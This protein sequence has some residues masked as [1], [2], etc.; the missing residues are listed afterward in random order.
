[1]YHNTCEEVSNST[2]LT[3]TSSAKSSSNDVSRNGGGGGQ[4]KVPI[5]SLYNH[6]VRSHRNL[7]NLAKVPDNFSLHFAR[8]SFAK[9]I[10]A[11][12]NIC[13]IQQKQIVSCFVIL[14][15]LIL[16]LANFFPHHL[17]YFQLIKNRVRCI[18]LTKIT[19]E[20][21][22]RAQRSTSTTNL[23]T[24]FLK[25]GQ[26]RPLFRLFLVFSNKHYKFLQQ[27]YM[28]K[29]VHPVYDAGIRTHDFWNV[30]L[31]P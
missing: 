2:R 27:K 25:M 1:M 7:E 9:G 17:K 15:F 24:V 12:P 6:L 16:S 18:I 29:N 13:P 31:L 4:S 5:L 19:N 10:T 3:M 26:P 11:L 20:N 14:Q 30:S 22:L 23:I 21:A 28:W 8:I